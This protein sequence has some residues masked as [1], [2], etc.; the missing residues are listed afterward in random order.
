M[1]KRFGM[2]ALRAPEGRMEAGT[3]RR[4]GSR[5]AAAFFLLAVGAA[6]FAQDPGGPRAMQGSAARD[7]D[8]TL[9]ARE[10]LAQAIVAERTHGRSLR[11]GYHAWLRGQLAARPLSELEALSEGDPSAASSPNVLGEFSDRELVFNPVTP[12]RVFDTR[13]AVAGK[14]LANTQRNFLV[15]GQGV[16]LS[17]QGGSATGCNIN[18]GPAKAVVINFVAV[19]PSGAGNLRAWAVADPQPAAPT[20]AVMNFSPTLSALAN[21]IVVPI[22]D[23]TKTS[24]VAG[25]LRLQADVSAVHVVGDVVGYFTP[26][27]TRTDS[28]ILS[29][30]PVAAG[31]NFF[32]PG[33]PY[34][35]SYGNQRCLVVASLDIEG[36]AIANGYAYARVALRNVTSGTNT[37][38]AWGHYLP[39]AAT[40]L[41][42]ATSNMTVEL[43]D[44]TQ[45][46]FGCY[47]NASGDYVGKTWYCNVSY[48]C[49]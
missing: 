3:S 48:F 8:A 29:G 11:P 30:S 37:E 14:L 5:V 19:A 32:F 25:D 9:A 41:T 33:T 44:D 13:F 28:R 42:S 36:G 34:Y 24:C 26:V 2:T 15:T 18:F 20:A 31:G 16:D 35:Y 49:Q 17:S 7:D 21:G 40:G 43:S 45:Y 4:L 22:C 38:F 6:A 1:E 10:E 23:V 46:A 39:P 27:F 12:C 47:V